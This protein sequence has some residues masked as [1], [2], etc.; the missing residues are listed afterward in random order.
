M[1]AL[2]EIKKA[3]PNMFRPLKWHHF[4][5][6]TEH[7]C[8]EWYA[9]ATRGM[10]HI[11]DVRAKFPNDRPFYAKELSDQFDTLEQAKDAVQNRHELDIVMCLDPDFRS[12]IESL[13]RE[14][15]ALKEENGGL[16][17]ENSDLKNE[18]WPEWAKAVLKVIRSHTGYDGYDDATEGV[19]MPLELE[20]H[21]SELQSVN[22]RLQSRAE[23]AEAEV[24]CITESRDGY[25]KQRDQLQKLYDDER[26]SCI[27]EAK[28]ATDMAADC[29]DAQARAETAESCLTQLRKAVGKL[30][31]QA[32]HVCLGAHTP[33]DIK[34]AARNLATPIK[35]VHT[36]LAS[37][38]GE[39][40][41]N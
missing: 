18:P 7:G 17:D 9:H 24:K 36:I 3:F 14:N 8:G 40:H 11:Y 33:A 22:D 12:T 39:H 2:E 20:E 32:E 4:D 31:D 19:D 26:A 38:G 13:Q 41:G 15:A 5:G 30:L 1:T 25:V 37:T 35:N 29:N 6:P 21:L 23:A 10:Y 16:L 27:R 34:E 28:L